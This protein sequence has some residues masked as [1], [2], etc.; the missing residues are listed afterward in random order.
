M[1]GRSEGVKKVGSADAEEKETVAGRRKEKGKGREGR[2]RRDGDGW[3]GSFGKVGR[4]AD[5]RRE[6]VA[7]LGEAEWN[8][9]GDCCRVHVARDDINPL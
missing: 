4:P 7:A 6:R 8:S 2:K 1:R 3:D 9:V 5:R